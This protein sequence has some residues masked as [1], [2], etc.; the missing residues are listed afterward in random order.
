MYPEQVYVAL[1]LLR[2]TPKC[3]DHLTIKRTDVPE[4]ADLGTE[5]GRQTGIIIQIIHSYA[6]SRLSFTTI[7]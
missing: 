1:W 4:S 7:Q 2:S 3:R 6:F 5:K